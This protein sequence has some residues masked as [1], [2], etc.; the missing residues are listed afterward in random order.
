MLDMLVDFLIDV[1]YIKDVYQYIAILN[2]LYRLSRS[3]MEHSDSRLGCTEAK[4]LKAQGDYV[5]VKT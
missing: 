2:N 4:P 3:S 5:K 1:G